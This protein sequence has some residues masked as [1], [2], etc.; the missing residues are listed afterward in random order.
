MLEM[1]RPRSHFPNTSAQ[2]VRLNSDHWSTQ[3]TVCVRSSFFH[4][5]SGV[6]LH[7]D[8]GASSQP[9]RR[10][11]EDIN[12]VMSP[13]LL[14]PTAGLLSPNLHMLGRDYPTVRLSHISASGC[15]SGTSQDPHSWIWGSGQEEWP[16]RCP[17]ALWPPPVRLQVGGRI[18][19]LGKQ[20]EVEGWVRVRV[21]QYFKT[22]AAFYKDLRSHTGT[23]LVHFSSRQ[24]LVS[25]LL[26]IWYLL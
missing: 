5:P 20:E 10:C 26:T 23:W 7:E 12:P 13:S 11:L 18:W 14:K 25:T 4:L 17:A 24:V 2:S 16:G 22:N 9:R 21:S 3:T 8:K 15:R 6:R 19:E 1:M